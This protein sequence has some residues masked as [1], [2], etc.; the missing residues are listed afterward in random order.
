LNTPTVSGDTMPAPCLAK[1]GSKLLSQ[2]RRRSMGNTGSRGILAACGLQL[3]AQ[4]L[5]VERKISNG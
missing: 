4:H 2:L 3:P 1:R 5:I